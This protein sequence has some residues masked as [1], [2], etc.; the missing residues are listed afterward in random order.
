[1]IYSLRSRGDRPAVGAQED[2]DN[3]T[4]DVRFRSQ[5]FLGLYSS[6]DGNAQQQGVYLVR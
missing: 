1:M 6:R 2:L 5:D 4:S 3:I